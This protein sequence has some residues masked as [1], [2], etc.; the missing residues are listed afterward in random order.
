MKTVYVVDDDKNLVKVMARTLETLLD[1]KVQAF[2]D[3]ILAL[4]AAVDKCPDAMVVD[5]MMPG[6]D[7]VAFTRELRRQGITTE[8]VMVTAYRTEAMTNLLPTN[9]VNTV[10]FKPV[11]GM[12]LAEKVQQ[13]LRK[14]SA[15]TVGV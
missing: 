3:P 9:G 13:A 10:L 15:P 14:K 12:E 1:V 11:P 6:M 7:G 2:T 8:V 4:G 5:M